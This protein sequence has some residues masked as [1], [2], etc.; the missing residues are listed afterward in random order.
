MLGEPR[1]E[2]AADA[3]GGKLRRHIDLWRPKPVMRDSVEVVI[4]SLDLL[5]EQGS[6]ENRKL[7]VAI[8]LA[9]TI[10]KEPRLP[11]DQ[12]RDLAV[13]EFIQSEVGPNRRT[14]ERRRVLLVAGP[15]SSCRK[16]YGRNEDREKTSRVLAKRQ[17][18]NCEAQSI[19]LARSDLGR[20]VDH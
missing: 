11:E 9:A 19:E 10:A 15:L 14:R 6:R 7:P 18:K 13:G 4:D 2:A 3:I 16:T 5:D 1:V 12:P 8:G 17:T 20:H